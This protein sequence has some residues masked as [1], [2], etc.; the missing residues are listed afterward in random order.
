MS[1]ATSLPSDGASSVD[2]SI[3]G[4]ELDSSVIGTHTDTQVEDTSTS[5]TDEG[6]GDTTSVVEPG[7][8][9]QPTSAKEDGR[10]IPQWI[11]G[12]QETNPAAYQKAKTD[13]FDH[14]ERRSIHPTVQSAREE[15]NLVQ[16]LGGTNGVTK[17]REDAGFFKEAAGQFAK[18]D[19]A[20]VKDLWDEDPIAAALH[21]SP[22][23]DAFKTRDIEGY[24]SMVARMWDKEF[25]DVGFATGLQSLQQ[26]IQAGN[27]EDALALLKSFGDWKESITGLANRA[28]DPRVKTLLAE[29]AKNH[30]TKQQ[31]ER[32]DFLKGYRTEAINTVEA[33]G[34]KV[35]ES[36]FRDA[37]MDETDRRDLL[38]DMLT[39]ANRAVLADKTF[40]ETRDRH[41]A[42]GDSH[43]ALQL[44]RA[45]FAQEFTSASKRIANRY[46][47]GVIPPTP[48]PGTPG[49]Q[50]GVKVDPGWV[51][52]TTRPDPSEI[53]RNKTTNEMIISGKRAILKNGKKVDWSNLKR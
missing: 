30:E 2:A 34:R 35:L 47:R 26:A 41:L 36:F 11:K 18:G 43:S 4:S 28:E 9:G 24:K 39:A 51:A 10:T 44:T 3:S 37:K 15:H 27:K 46:N 45:R 52:V 17:L 33:D 40:V 21:V 29:R 16:S 25:K 13:F 31:S 42:N 8:E 7:T 53:D 50:P 32:Q 49:T 1:S 6:T 22:M 5:T 23:L 12:L 19:P 14:R 20:F 38:K 48:K